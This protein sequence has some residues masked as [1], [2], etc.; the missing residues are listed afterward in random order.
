MKRNDVH[1][2]IVEYSGIEL[3]VCIEIEPTYSEFAEHEKLYMCT[4]VG[5]SCQSS[6]Q[7]SYFRPLFF[8]DP[9]MSLMSRRTVEER[10]ERSNANNAYAT[11]RK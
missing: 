9:W 10:D 4:M 6:M 1:S 11:G 2:L 3:I 7:A 5:Q 8:E